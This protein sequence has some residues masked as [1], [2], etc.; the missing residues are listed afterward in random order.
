MSIDIKRAGGGSAWLPALRHRPQAQARLFCF[1]YAGGSVA[2]YVEWAD[3][4]P[5]TIDVRPVQVPGRWNRSHE[6]P[7]TRPE[8]IVNALLPVLL[9]LLDRP[10]VMFGHSMGALLAFEMTRTLR[11]GK[12][13]LPAHLFVSGRRA[14]QIPDLDLPSA[15]LPDAEFIAELRK[16]NGTPDEVLES[17]EL[18]AL[19]LPSLRADFAVCRAYAYESEPPLALPITVTSGED[20]DESEPGYLEA[21][22]EQ[23]TGRCEVRTYPGDHFYLR[24]ATGSLIEL[25]HEALHRA[26][27]SSPHGALDGASSSVTRR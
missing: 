17:A 8:D 11:R 26:L 3:R 14:P 5:Q 23:T 9:P 15:D 21:W 6:P 19:V 10:F 2:S 13:P 25:V 7:L 27:H 1:P 18:M 22:R 4:L 16:F 12:H 24:A 20:D